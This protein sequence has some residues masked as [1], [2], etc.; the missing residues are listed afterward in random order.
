M[1][2]G[3]EL[4]PSFVGVL[5]GLDGVSCRSRLLRCEH[6]LAL[7][8]RSLIIDQP[9]SDLLEQARA[10]SLEIVQGV[11][12]ISE[13]RLGGD[14]QDLVINFTLVDQLQ[15]AEN[16]NG[17]DGAKRHGFIRDLNHIDGVVVA[18]P[19][20]PSVLAGNALAGVLPGCGMKP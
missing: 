7:A 12:L 1:S 17:R 11:D 15:I 19:F 6:V 14:G 20:L 3:N 2:I 5:D 9:I 10:L 4:L 18:A 8:I 13:G 16:A